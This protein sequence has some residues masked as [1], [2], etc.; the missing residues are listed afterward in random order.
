MTWHC[1]Q[2]TDNNRSIRWCPNK[3]CSNL[4]EVSEFCT[5]DSVQ[6]N[7]GR[8]LCIRCA[9]EGHMPASCNHVFLWLEKEK[10]DSENLGWIKANTKPCPK[11]GSNIEKNQ[12]CNHMNCSK[13]KHDFCWLCLTPWKEHGSKTGGYYACNL[14]ETR[15]QQDAS[16][17][18]GEQSQQDAKNE[19]QRYMFHFE[20]YNNHG[21]SMKTCIKH[22]DKIKDTM[23]LLHELKNYP[24]SELEFFQEAANAIVKCRNVLKY[25]YVTGYFMESKGTTYDKGS[26][27]L[28][29]YQ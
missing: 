20:R 27:E 12:G 23:K 11:C 13:C 4:V 5:L 29:K 16:F 28:F 1:R 3:K 2:F 24:N 15:K 26:I 21:K 6:C 14:Y 7:C 10:S 8:S 25:T 17:A 18:K 22:M 19:L 9:E